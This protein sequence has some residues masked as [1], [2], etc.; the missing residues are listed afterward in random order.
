MIKD[1][2]IVGNSHELFHIDSD[3]IGYIR[4]KGNYSNIYLT[5]GKIVPV[6]MQLGDVE[7]EIK[8]RLPNYG[9]DFRRL[10]RSLIINKRNLLKIDFTSKKPKLEFSSKRTEDYLK[11][12]KDGYKAGYKAGVL[13]KNSSIPSDTMILEEQ[14][15]NLLKNCQESKLSKEPINELMKELKNSI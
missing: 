12:Y 15:D 5:N 2:L 11:G 13:G 8:K 6:L 14:T 9:K 7:E 3:N 1:F 4:A 10:G